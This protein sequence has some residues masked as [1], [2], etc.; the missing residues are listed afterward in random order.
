[1]REIVL[2]S[3]LVT[4]VTERSALDSPVMD[5]L[6]RINAVTFRH[7]ETRVRVR[8]LENRHDKTP[9]FSRSRSRLTISE[10]TLGASR[11]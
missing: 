1:M 4:H 5:F 6:V 2:S 8:S 3:N 7:T 11:F 9:S 10:H